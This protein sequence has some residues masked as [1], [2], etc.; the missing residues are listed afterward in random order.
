[1]ALFTLQVETAP[2]VDA[3]KAAFDLAALA[4]RLGVN[5]VT[6]WNGLTVT[7]RPEMTAADVLRDYDLSRRL[8]NY[9]KS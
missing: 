4:K 7:A 3:D 8:E 5:V 2:T 1:M 9:P 6:E